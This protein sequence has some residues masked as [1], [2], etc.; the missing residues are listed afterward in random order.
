MRSGSASFRLE[1]A[2]VRYGSE[3]AVEEVDLEIEPGEVVGFVGPSGAGKTTLLRLLNGTLRPTSGKVLIGGDDLGSLPVRRLR[4]VRSR[5][6]MVHQ[7]LS[8]IPN[9][10]VL[11]NVLIGRLGRLSLLGSAR[12]LFFPPRREVRRVH[13]LLERVGI[14]E[15][16]YER[17]DRL[18]G[19]QRQRVA[20]ARAL[21]QEPAAL[22]PDEPISSLDPARSRDTMRLL[23]EVCREGGITL[24]A[25][26]HDLAAARDFLPRLVGL[27]G[28]R[29]VFDRPTT[30]LDDDDFHNLYDLAPE[31]MLND[32]P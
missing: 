31:E 8:L 27:R 5:I 28:G 29:V 19:G 16:L 30:E 9:L 2:C 21:Y 4:E 22:L 12:L 15:K 26:L 18:S 24:C 10:R 13:E 23:I 7:D 1:K 14:G 20:I 6:G 25:S 17:T 32:G 3:A 11:R